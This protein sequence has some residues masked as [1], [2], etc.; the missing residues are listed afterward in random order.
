MTAKV[1]AWSAAFLDCCLIA[2][3][4]S[5]AGRCFEMRESISADRL[6]ADGW[7]Q[8]SVANVASATLAVIEGAL[9]LARVSA[10]VSHH[11]SAKGCTCATSQPRTA[12]KATSFETLRRGRR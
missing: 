6:R 9:L 5:A 4:E 2:G 3:D 1:A 11:E 12:R 7:P 10:D 8:G